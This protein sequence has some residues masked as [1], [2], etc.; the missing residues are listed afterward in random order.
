MVLKLVVLPPKNPPSSN[1]EKNIRQIPVRQ[2]LT[3][4]LKIV[5]VIK[6]KENLRNCQN[7]EKPKET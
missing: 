3:S 1:H 2:I 4:L 7:Q 6:T 5:K